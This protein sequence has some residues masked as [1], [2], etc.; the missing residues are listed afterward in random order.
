MDLPQPG[1]ES[2][3]EGQGGT[4][5]RTS[6][7]ARK[8]RGAAAQVEREKQI[9]EREKERERERIEAAGRRSGRANKRHVD[10]ENSGFRDNIS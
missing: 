3:D 8:A 10:G 5:S 1:I 7:A 4:K 6:N 2:D 9:R